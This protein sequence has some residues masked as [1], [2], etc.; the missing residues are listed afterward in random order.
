MLNIAI[1]QVVT[2]RVQITEEN[3]LFLQWHRMV[4]Q[5]ELH[6]HMGALPWRL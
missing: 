3:L 1:W 5:A 6:D 2:D 4:A